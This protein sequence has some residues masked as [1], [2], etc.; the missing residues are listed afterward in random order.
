MTGSSV[1]R[2]PD[3]GFDL[4]DIGTAVWDPASVHAFVELHIERGVVLESS[5]E[6]IGV[7]TAI[8][9]P[10]DLRITLQEPRTT[11]ARP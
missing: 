7:V 11:P 4:D 1:P 5:G 6:Q 8:T 9:A 10:H 3:A 2:Q